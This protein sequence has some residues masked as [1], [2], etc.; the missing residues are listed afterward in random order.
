MKRLSRI[1][2]VAPVLLFLV[3]AAPSCPPVATLTVTVSGPG[4]VTS[5]PPGID[6]G[7]GGAACTATFT[8]PEV[9]LTTG[10]DV[11]VRWSGDCGGNGACELVLDGSNAVTATTWAP[12]VMPF[13]DGRPGFA[14]RVAATGG[15][16]ILGVGTIE[17]EFLRDN[18]WSRGFTAAGAVTWSNEYSG[19]DASPDAGRAIAGDSAGNA[20]VAGHWYS[21]T[22]TRFNWFVRKLSAAGAVQWTRIGETIVDHD[23]LMGIDV[24]A[25]GNLVVAGYQ[26]DAGGSRQAVLRKLG[27]TGLDLWGRTSDGSA[28]SDD[29]ASAVAVHPAGTI[30]VA[31]H[32]TNTGQGRDGWLAAYASDGTPLWSAEHDGPTHGDDQI[33]D[34]A[35]SGAGI[36][37]I[38]GREDTRAYLA[39]HGL[40]GALLWEQ[41]TDVAGGWTGVAV[42]AGGDVVVTSAGTPARYDIDGAL[43]WSR[44]S[45]GSDVAFD[46][47]GNLLLASGPSLVKLFQ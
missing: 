14:E 47:S 23:E 43:I 34:V 39:V 36:I 31:G 32:E 45:G 6:C 26:P 18:I 37:A 10:G 46:G 13:L 38:A 27:P 20:Y 17:H 16:A 33:R 30:V 28:G 29:G 11:T 12:L 24:D 15:D 9:T 25:T 40:D 2:P 42:G 1:A 19:L 41:I 22:N 21:H 44:P 3:T 8:V 7:G 4:R 35:T 5:T